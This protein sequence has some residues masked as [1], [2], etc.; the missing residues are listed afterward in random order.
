[1]KEYTIHNNHR[2]DKTND[3]ITALAKDLG[4]VK[5]VVRAGAEVTRFWSTVGKYG[6]YSLIGGLTALGAYF[7][8]EWFIQ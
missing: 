6:K 3:R 7:G 8:K 4:E 5:E 1:M 2:H